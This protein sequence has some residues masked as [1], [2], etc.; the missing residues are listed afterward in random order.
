M[1]FVGAANDDERD[2]ASNMLNTTH[3]ISS[4][5]SSPTKDMDEGEET[6]S[7]RMRTGHLSMINLQGAMA[8]QWQGCVGSTSSSSAD[9][10]WF[11]VAFLTTWTMLLIGYSWYM[12]RNVNKFSNVQVP[13]FPDT[14]NAFTEPQV[15]HESTSIEGLVT[16]TLVRACGR[17]RRAT[18]AGNIGAGMRYQQVQLWLESCLQR[19]P[20]ASLQDRQKALDSLGDEYELS[21]DDSSPTYNLG[22][23]ERAPLT[24]SHGE[25]H[26]CLVRLLELQKVEIT[27]ELLS[28]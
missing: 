11:G 8:M 15:T 5:E 20:T 10:S 24:N 14:L 1:N 27:S 25:I 28:S 9:G 19:L 26:Q 16:W 12:M 18:E 17:L 3:D 21:E 6:R 22:R 7:R 23:D 2:Q 13:L 4:H